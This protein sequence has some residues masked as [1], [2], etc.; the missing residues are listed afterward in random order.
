MQTH[1]VTPRAE[2]TALSSG[3]A[4]L[5]AAVAFAALAGPAAA[6]GRPQ[7]L[8]VQA[9]ADLAA[10]TLLIRGEYFVWA[11]DDQAKVTLAG[12]PLTVL[13]LDVGYILA[14]LPP[15]L[16][17]G[18]YLRGRSRAVTGPSRTTPSR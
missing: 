7:L 4:A 18:G 11:N 6:Q 15:A 2:Q 14:E 5:L 10:E 8:I 13:S 16:A 17:P 1:L 3:L 12:N 9:E